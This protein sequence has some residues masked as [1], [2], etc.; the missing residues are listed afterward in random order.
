M[1]ATIRQD[2]VVGAVVAF[3]SFRSLMARVLLAFTNPIL[4]E[5][6]DEQ[7]GRLVFAASTTTTNNVE[8]E[9]AV[10]ELR[11]APVGS[12]ARSKRGILMREYIL[13]VIDSQNYVACSCS[14]NRGPRIPA[15]RA[16]SARA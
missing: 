11:R 12:R 6:V 3:R 4:V 16:R 5:V 2:C 1:P 15:D 9:I 14:S 10:S 7:T 8:T 13:H